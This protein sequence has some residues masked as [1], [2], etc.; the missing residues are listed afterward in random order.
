MK[1]KDLQK[2]LKNWPDDMSI[3][4]N[5]GEEKR[6]LAFTK[7]NI[8]YHAADDYIDESGELI[9]GKLKRVIVINPPVN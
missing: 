7:D 4:L 2:L 6:M 3:R 1:N 9:H 5:I 8:C